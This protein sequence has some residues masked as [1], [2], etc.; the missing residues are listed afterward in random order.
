M[1]LH[2]RQGSTSAAGVFLDSNHSLSHNTYLPC[3]FL[4]RF[5]LQLRPPQPDKYS[6]PVLGKQLEKIQRRN[7]HHHSVLPWIQH[8]G[9]LVENISRCSTR[10]FNRHGYRALG[11]VCKAIALDVAGY[12]WQSLESDVQFHSAD[13]WT[14][15]QTWC[16]RCC[17][18]ILDATWHQAVESRHSNACLFFQQMKLGEYLNPVNYCPFKTLIYLLELVKKVGI[19]MLTCYIQG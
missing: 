18:E 3:F 5:S 10:W 8:Y 16:L 9:K 2:V 13:M 4:P 19:I 7:Y 11:V 1:P 6:C 14:R 15:C 17:E 12:M